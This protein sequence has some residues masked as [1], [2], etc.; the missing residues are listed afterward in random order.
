[1]HEV[2]VEHYEVGHIEHSRLLGL[3]LRQKFPHNWL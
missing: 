1:M 3:F 2:H